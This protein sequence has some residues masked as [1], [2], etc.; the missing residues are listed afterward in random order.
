MIPRYPLKITAKELHSRL[1]S[2]QFVV[3]KRTVERDLLALSKLFPLVSDERD[4]PYGWSWAKDAPTFSLPGLSHNEALTLVMVEQHLKPSNT[5]FTRSPLFSAAS[6]SIC[7]A[8]FLITK[9]DG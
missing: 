4:K 8:A 6:S 9:T 3:T 2:E 1:Q 7:I 5:A